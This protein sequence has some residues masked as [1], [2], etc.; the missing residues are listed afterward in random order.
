[1]QRLGAVLDGARAPKQVLDDARQAR[2]V[3]V[4]D[5]GVLFS[6]HFASPLKMRAS[7]RLTAFLSGMPAAASAC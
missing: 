1:V 5:T 7:A 6:S 2:R 4:G 3:A